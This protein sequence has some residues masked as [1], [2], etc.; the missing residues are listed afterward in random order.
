M[1]SKLEETLGLPS[2]ED[3]IKQAEDLKIDQISETDEDEI[4]KKSEEDLK[5]LE[6][7]SPEI[8]ETF[9][10]ALS[11]SKDLEAKLSDK[12]GLEEHDKEMDDISDM[13]TDAFAELMDLGMNVSPAHAGS[14]FQSAST[15]LNTALSAKNS[16]SDKKLKMWR[17]QIEQ[18]RLM[19]DLER[20]NGTTF[21]GEVTSD[22]SIKFD[23]NK[24]LE[25]L[26]QN[27]IDVDSEKTDK[28]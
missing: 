17:L 11:K 13:A 15:L 8:A 10:Q 5:A 1:T 21:E 3:A 18:A 27:P 16:K 20:E 25:Q 24:L 22:G 28:K 12:E 14:I 2:L 6:E 26:R 9:S 23:R 19:R 7:E 4:I